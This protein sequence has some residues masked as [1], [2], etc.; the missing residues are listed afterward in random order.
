MIK[1]EMSMFKNDHIAVYV[2]DLERSRH[3]YTTCFGAKVLS[4]PSSDFLELQI[5]EVRLHLLHT[6]TLQGPPAE[7]RHCN[8]IAH[9]CLNV[10]S[11][12]DLEVLRDRIRVLNPVENTPA[13]VKIASPIGDSHVEAIPPMHVMYFKDPDGILI[14]IRAYR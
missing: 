4:K 3:F 7:A 14:E 8:G 6:Q 12:A 9:F 5:D 1:G 2:S 10:H 11:R 13:E